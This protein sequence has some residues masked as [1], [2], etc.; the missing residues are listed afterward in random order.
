MVSHKA[1]SHCYSWTLYIAKK[2]PLTLP[3]L[4]REVHGDLQ[5]DIWLWSGRAWQ[6]E[7]GGGHVLGVYGWCQEWEQED[8]HGQD[9]GVH[10][11]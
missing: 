2:F 5:A 11:V 1:L 4:Q 8:G 9:R 6:E 3:H 10:G 7:G